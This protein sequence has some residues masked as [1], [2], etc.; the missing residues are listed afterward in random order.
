MYAVTWSAGAPFVLWDLF[1][2][3]QTEDVLG[4]YKVIAILQLLMH[5]AQ[6]EFRAWI[7][8]IVPLTP[9][10]RESLAPVEGI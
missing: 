4:F 7:H 6:T 5:W 8:G 10:E 2:C 3:G 1:D 9:E